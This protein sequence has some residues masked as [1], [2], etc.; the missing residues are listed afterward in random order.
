MRRLQRAMPTSGPRPIWSISRPFACGGGHLRVFDHLKLPY[1]I[2]VAAQD[3]Y[4]AGGNTSRERR[5]RRRPNPDQG[6]PKTRASS[7]AMTAQGTT[8]SG[9]RPGRWQNIES[10]EGQRQGRSRRVR[11]KNRH[12]QPS[13][14][15]M[16][17]Y[18][19]ADSIRYRWVLVRRNKALPSTAGEAKQPSSSLLVASTS[20]ARPGLSTM[21][22]PC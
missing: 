16:V 15:S 2:G 18:G 4:S 3:A 5:A 11:K 22:F 6:D 10:G 8:R 17:C 1:Q 14:D 7:P 19:F 12:T 21:V 13:K 9:R 20:R